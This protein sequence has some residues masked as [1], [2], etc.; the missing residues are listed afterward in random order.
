MNGGKLL[1]AEVSDLH[2]RVILLHAFDW[3]DEACTSETIPLLVDLV[4]AC[5]DRKIGVL[6]IAPAT[7]DL[8]VK[9]ASEAYGMRWPVAIVE[10]G[11]SSP[12]FNT[13]IHGTDH[14]FVIGRSGGLLW[15]GNPREERDALLATLAAELPRYPAPAIGRPLNESLLESLESYHAADWKKAEALASKLVKKLGKKD[16]ELSKTISVDARHLLDK[17]DHHKGELLEQARYSMGK[18][19]AAGFLAVQAAVRDGFPKTA[20]A[21]DVAEIAKEAVKGMSANTFDDTE[22]WMEL[23]AQRPVLFPIHKSRAGDRLAKAIPK[24]LRRTVND[25]YCTQ[26]ARYLLETYERAR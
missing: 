11:S 22:R 16:D 17:L 1:Q 13:E 23:H 18:R 14:F 15:H 9:V 3:K 20:L 5:A 8:D 25:I 21:R 24:F 2:G 26:Q 19:S 4:A 6:S 10:E 12:Y 7:E